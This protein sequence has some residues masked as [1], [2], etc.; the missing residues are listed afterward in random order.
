MSHRID[1]ATGRGGGALAAAALSLTLL[2]LV[3]PARPIR[4]QA[5]GEESGRE[6]SGQ[7]PQ[8][9]TTDLTR[10][11]SISAN[12]F[13]ISVVFLDAEPIVEVRINGVLQKLPVGTELLLT[14][15]IDN[16]KPETVVTI[17]AK[18]RSGHS[19]E[20]SFLVINPEAKA[21]AA[22][23]VPPVVVQTD[24]WESATSLRSAR[25][26]AAA[27]SLGGGVYVFGGYA[28]VTYN[29]DAALSVESDKSEYVGTSELVKPG[30][31]D[32]ISGA[33]V[34]ASLVTAAVV[35]GKVYVFESRRVLHE[36]DPTRGAWRTIESPLQLNR[37]GP[38]AAA[39]DQIYIFG[40]VFGV[41][42]PEA[43]APAA[44][45]GAAREGAAKRPAD[46]K[47]RIEVRPSPLFWRYTPGTNTWKVMGYMPAPRMGAAACKVGDA[48]Y[49]VGGF[50]GNKALD[51]V[52]VYDVVAATWSVKP[53]MPVARAYPA[54]FA[55][56]NR[57]LVFGGQA[58]GTQGPPLGSVT[59][60]DPNTNEWT[61]RANMPTARGDAASALLDGSTYL[62]GGSTG[63]PTDKVEIYK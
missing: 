50:D 33:P 59:L 43:G 15:E 45:G 24:K 9:L 46:A 41:A 5:G 19:R 60:Y 13:R 31:R 2:A 6:E 27:V 16:R 38:A 56:N 63:K 20:K 28:K 8:I 22:K 29:Y 58:D 35:R 18:N 51:Q 7:G 39:G 42:V 48:I 37:V 23:A 34:F 25:A 21:E 3:L 49:V 54:C 4:A 62:L 10:R 14:A 52:D 44:A 53:P 12:S 32:V 40:G 11:Q 61:A 47:P 36:Y 26:G 57:L 1:K 30:G 17:S 55:V